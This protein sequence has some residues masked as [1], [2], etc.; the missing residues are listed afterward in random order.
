[1]APATNGRLQ[2]ATGIA[3]GYTED[4]D[5]DGRPA[6]LLLHA[7]A[8]SRYSFARLVPLLP[9]WLRTIAVDLRGHGDGDKPPTGYGLASLAADVVA[10]MDALDLPSAVLVGSSSGGY[11]AQQVAGDAPRRVAGLVL[12]GAPRDLRG[13]PSFADEIA[14]LTDPV[15]RDWARRFV[16]GLTRAQSL[17]GWYVEHRVADALRLPAATWRATFEG[18]CASEPPT[19]RGPIAVPALVVSGEDDE[20][21]DLGQTAAL[22]A[23]LPGARWLRYPDTGHCV[24][25]EQPARLA[26]DI[27]DFL[28]T[29]APAGP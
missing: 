26:A 28:A 14:A 10:A 15:D 8:E 1:M 23:D 4:G 12:A 18:L 27:T 17:P 20:L 24:L 5:P 2:L 19:E 6:L 16:T 25:W 3:T 22:V 29:V 21:L 11:V 9:P 7:W 13:H